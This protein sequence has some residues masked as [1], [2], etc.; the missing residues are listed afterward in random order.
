[1]PTPAVATATPTLGPVRRCGT[2]TAPI[3]GRNV[4]NAATASS[5]TM[6]AG[7]ST[8]AEIAAAAHAPSPALTTAS[9]AP[10]IT[11]WR[12]TLVERVYVTAAEAVPNTDDS[13]LVAIASTV[14][15]PVIRMAGSCN[16][17]PP[18][19]T[20]STHPAPAA[21]VSNTRTCSS[22]TRHS[23]EIPRETSRV[24]KP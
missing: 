1:M 11:T 3:A 22:G 17:P 16:R 13:L 19:T 12:S 6:T 5:T 2:G 20:A 14:G 8:S 24:Y 18:P 4:T 21:A 7:R 15:M 23:P 9:A 10:G